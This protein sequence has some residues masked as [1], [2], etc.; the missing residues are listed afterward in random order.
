MGEVI[1]HCLFLNIGKS[2]SGD[3]KS[4]LNTVIIKEESN[5]RFCSVAFVSFYHSFPFF[6]S[7]EPTP[8]SSLSVSITL[9]YNPQ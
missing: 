6:P 8:E 2:V 3:V 5:T 1:Y 7:T 4:L 9:F